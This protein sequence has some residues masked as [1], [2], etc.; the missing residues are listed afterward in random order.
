M[1]DTRPEVIAIIP[2]HMG[3]TRFP[4]KALAAETGRALVL[5]VADAVQRSNAVSR[6]IVASEN[7]EIAQACESAGIEHIITGQGHP[8]GS[9]RISEAAT[10]LHGDVILNVQGDEPEIEPSTI[11]ATIAAL[12][13]DKDAD[14]ATAATPLRDDDDP[15]DPNL[16][17]VVTGLDGHA[18]Y[19]SRSL[20][21]MNRDG[22]NTEYLRHIGLYAYR[23]ATLAAY[24]TLAPTPLETAERLEQLRL[25]E[26]GYRITV[27]QV[28]AGH[29]GIDTAEQYQAFVTRWRARQAN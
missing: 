9:S 5:H 12:I 17:K 10:G 1:S 29:P 4:G 22:E 23:P 6:V 16:V 18:L 13:T 15:A 25:L 2:T 19:F 21:P 27:A 8:N 14:V 24:A 20:I 11:D 3:S 28:D 7:T 26:H